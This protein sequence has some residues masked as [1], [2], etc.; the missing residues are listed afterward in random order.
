MK[1]ETNDAF[2]HLWNVRIFFIEFKINRIS[3]DEYDFGV[4]SMDC[5]GPKG[6][7]TKVNEVCMPGICWINGCGD[8]VV[9]YVRGT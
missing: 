2:A 4:V 1:L 6:N 3:E 8:Q 5:F 9:S 7:K